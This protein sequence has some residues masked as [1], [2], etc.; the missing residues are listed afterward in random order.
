M[1]RKA[2]DED[3]TKVLEEV[4]AKVYNG[5]KIAAHLRRYLK[6]QRAVDKIN[7]DAQQA[8]SVHRE[9]QAAARKAAAEDGYQKK[10][11]NTVLK[12]LK[13]IDQIDR[14]DAGLDD[15]QK[16]DFKGM[17]D[18]LAGTPLGEAANRQTERIPLGA[19]GEEARVH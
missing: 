11:F 9:E 15:E 3:E 19:E 6:A 2:K 8:A 5:K 18:A 7:A 12:K 17:C 1:V 13:L 4:E 14:V 10:A 16:K